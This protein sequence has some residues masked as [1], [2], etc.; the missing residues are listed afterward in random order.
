MIC[1]EICIPL[2]DKYTLNLNK[3]DQVN[4]PIYQGAQLKKFR[5]KVPSMGNSDHIV[6]FQSSP[7]ELTFHIQSELSAKDLILEGP[8]GYYFSKAKSDPQASK[9][10][11]FIVPY[12][13]DKEKG[14]LVGQKM[15]VTHVFGDGQSQEFHVTVTAKP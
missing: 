8:E 6:A 2:T 13:M 11:E 3:P 9:P 10:H 15:T 12:E 1:E 5:S 7:Q 14:P 4:I